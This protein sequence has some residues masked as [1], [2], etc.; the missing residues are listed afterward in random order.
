MWSVQCAACSKQWAV[1]CVQCSL[2]NVQCAVCSVQ[3]AVCSVQCA[4]C[5]VQCA[6]FSEKCMACQTSVECGSVITWAVDIPAITA[7]ESRPWLLLILPLSISS[8]SSLN[9]LPQ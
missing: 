8:S 6:V 9:F 2:F 7:L 3:C 1:C 4:V 5:S